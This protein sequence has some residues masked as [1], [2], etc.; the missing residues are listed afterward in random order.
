MDLVPIALGNQTHTAKTFACAVL[1][2]ATDCRAPASPET[3]KIGRIGQSN[4]NDRPWPFDVRRFPDVLRHDVFGSRRNSRNI[5]RA[6]YEIVRCGCV[7]AWARQLGRNDRAA[8][9]Q[10]TL[11]EERTTDKKLT[12]LAEG[13]VN[14]RAAS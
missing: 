14:M 2:K 4:R 7:N 3:P 5:S 8:I 9:L 13:K 1:D 6:R 10:K 11:D 12:S